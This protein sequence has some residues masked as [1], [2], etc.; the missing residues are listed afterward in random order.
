MIHER[1]HLWGAG[2]PG[3]SSCGRA[4]ALP[5]MADNLYSR[6]SRRHPEERSGKSGEASP[7][8]WQNGAHLMEMPANLPILAGQRETRR[9]RN[10]LSVIDRPMKASGTVG[11]SYRPIVSWVC[12]LPL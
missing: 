5:D 9:T 4:A 2:V 12:H 10:L 1:Y 7:S 11:A 6:N 3:K 8:Y